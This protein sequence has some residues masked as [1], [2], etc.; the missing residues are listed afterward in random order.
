M[1]GR[2]RRLCNSTVPLSALYLL[3]GISTVHTL[4]SITSSSKATN[5]KRHTKWTIPT[6]AQVLSHDPL[7][8][9]VPD[10]LTAD[11]CQAYIEYVSRLPQESNYTRQFR[12]SN[13]PKVSLDRSKLWPLPLLSLAAGIPSILKAITTGTIET[14]TPM[15]IFQQVQGPISVACILTLILVALAPPLIQSVSNQTARTSVA[16]ALNDPTD[17][18]FIRSF[19]DSICH[20][21]GHEW[22]KWE[23]PVVTR[24]DPGAI[25]A[26]HGDASPTLGSEWEFEGGQRVI[27]CICYLN[28]LCDDIGGGGDSGGGGQTYFDQLQIAVTPQRGTALFFFPAD[29]S[30]R[31]ADDRT[32]HESLPPIGHEKWIVQ[33]FGRIGPRVPP[34]LGI[35]DDFYAAT[36]N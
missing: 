32:T 15:E 12:R 5:H 1:T 21:T 22:D 4:S 35:P 16:V 33:L 3:F 31:R 14:E 19:V 17:L 6:N 30:T 8:Y 26:K 27:T 18:P 23:A 9:T 24:Y 28:N 36:T 34:P 10:V 7:I 2:R 25:F 29:Y 20:I 11:E 13:P